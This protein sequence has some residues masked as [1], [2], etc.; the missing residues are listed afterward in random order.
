VRHLERTNQALLLAVGLLLLL[1]LL[2]PMLPS[3]DRAQLALGAVLLGA[4]RLALRG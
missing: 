2:T 1:V 4:L 3:L